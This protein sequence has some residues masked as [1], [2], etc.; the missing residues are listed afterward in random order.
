[1]DASVEQ[2][3]TVL[4]L[5]GKFAS[6]RGRKMSEVLEAVLTTK[7]LASMGHVYGRD[8][9][10]TTDQADT[11]IRILTMWVEKARDAS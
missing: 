3:N 9:H 4:D 5:C 2:I 11:A 8:A 1:M 6:M 7:T 10:L